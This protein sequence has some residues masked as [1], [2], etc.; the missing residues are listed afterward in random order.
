MRNVLKILK[1][2]VLRL[3]HTPP[4]LVVVVALLL[5]P[6]VYTWYNVIGFW[7]PYDNTGNLRVCVVNQDAGGSSELTGSLNVGDKI[8]DQLHDN[9][10]LDWEFTTY[11]EAMDQLNA[12]TA[13]AAFVIP[14][15][16]T[17]DLLTITTGEF[18]QPKL[19]YYV[20]EKAGP[21]APKITD[22]GATTL[23]ETI[24]STFVSTVTDVAVKAIDAA[25]DDTRAQ[26]GESQSRAAQKIADAAA[27]VGEARTTLAGIKTSVTE[28][29]DKIDG[30]RDALSRAS[31]GIDEADAS[32]GELSET[33]A[34][35]QKTLSD[36]SAF[37]MPAVTKALGAAT[38]AASA[39]DGAAAKLTGSLGQAQGGIQSALAQGRAAVTESR[40][41]AEALRQSAAGLPAGSTE[42]ASLEAL[43]KNL[44]A[45]SDA[46]EQT[47]G[48]LEGL[49][50]RTQDTA[51]ALQDA[52]S[53]LNT[54]VQ[55]AS[56][57]MSSY[58]TGLF[59]TTIP[60][61]NSA[62]DALAET[63]DA[64]Q[65]ALATQRMLVQ[66]TTL[67][68]NQL[69]A[70]MQTAQATVDET[71]K[72]FASLESELGVVYSDVV[73]FGASDALA[74]LVGEEGLDADRIASFMAS[75]TEV[76]T[77]SLYPL[78][79]YGSAMAPL[80]MNLTFWIGAFMLLVI[81][82]QEVDGE[83]VPGLTLAQRYW[84]RFLFLAAMAVVQALVCCAGV[85]AIGVQAVS[86]P[87]LFVAAACASLAYLA[88]IYAFSVTLQHI[89]KGI[90]I[91]LVFAQIPGATGLYPIE[92]TSGFF[93]ALYPFF[94][95]TYGI[96]AMREAICGFYGNQYATDLL[97]LGLFFALFMAAGL[98]LRPLMA[99]VNRMVARQV[100]EGGLFNG[101]D[102]D[103]PVRPYRISQILRALS[104]KG[105]YD[106]EIARRY[107][108]FSHWY[109]RL[110]KAAL[111][112][113]IVVPVLLAVVFALTPAEKVWLL[114][115]WL[116][117]TVLIF[118]ALVVIESL[119]FSFERQM[120]LGSLSD[121]SL[122]GLYDASAAVRRAA[123][124]DATEGPA[125]TVAPASDR[126]SPGPASD[127]PA[128]P[129][130][131]AKG[132]EGD[133]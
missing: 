127:D 8:V 27:T 38:T 71:D 112:S 128:G 1:R 25:V 109:P 40:A 32:L 87:A 73:A 21:V 37:A 13:Y 34:A 69:D 83:G 76:V 90:C 96:G 9:H 123:D 42:R 74:R 81:M 60:A 91:I 16:F 49:N 98:L 33:S 26:A 70:T 64:L 58:S 95:F 97:V 111:I 105:G 57:S 47:L 100:R 36:F 78:N 132:G 72:L 114:T 22:T 99:N 43:A 14:S 121:E 89:G 59:G 80:F 51:Q 84:A 116:L 124:L 53:S 94:P 61:V 107:A 85:L 133:E 50:T 15:R 56:S 5:L 3:V 46:A 62:L 4:A 120:K 122:I 119:R 131:A 93:Q 11:D 44:D 18:T 19:Q 67:V 41:V 92:M 29:H 28:A 23:D 118:V 12:G 20:N 35:M 79:A 86:A 113:G 77:E 31:T 106:A 110:M 104:D 65:E 88:I 48:D 102:V 66:Q 2:D 7:N 17:A 10:Q 30:A 82:R 129:A 117:W 54:A 63:S 52:T 125:A 45:R 6:S 126:P 24:N 108:R 101:E 75:P 115:A 103:I 130:P 55:Q 68:V 39:A